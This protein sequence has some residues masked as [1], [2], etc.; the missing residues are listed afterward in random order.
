MSHGARLAL[1]FACAL[2]TNQLR[3][4]TPPDSRPDRDWVF[5][6]D[7][8]SNNFPIPGSATS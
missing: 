1:F 6:L 8:A 4:F 5:V 2:P 7:D 3:R